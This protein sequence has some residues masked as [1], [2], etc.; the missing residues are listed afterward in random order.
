MTLGTS[1]PK[2]HA[3]WLWVFVFVGLLFVKG[4]MCSLRHRKSQR[5]AVARHIDSGESGG[6]EAA[7]AAVALL[8]DFEF[9][10]ARAELRLAAP[11]QGLV[12][13]AYGSVFG[14]D[15]FRETE[16]ALGLAG[17][18]GMQAF[19]GLDAIPAAADH[20]LAVIGADRRHHLVRRIVAPGQSRRRGRLHG[21]NH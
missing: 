12:L 16:D 9:A 20:R 21:F 6:G 3:S 18:V 17:H 5:L 7:G 15:G 4:A 14:I 19:A 11:V 1:G 8:A 2:Q 10:L 13:E